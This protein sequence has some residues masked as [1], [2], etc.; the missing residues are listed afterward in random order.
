MNHLIDK[1]QLLPEVLNEFK[2]IKE[3]Q[4][5]Q[6]TIKGTIKEFKRISAS[7]F[8]VTIDRDNQYEVHAKLQI[9]LNYP[10]CPP[11][12]KITMQKR[13]FNARANQHILNRVD[14]GDLLAANNLRQLQSNA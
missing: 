5:L 14:Q 9:P 1:Q 8:E 4:M 10:D 13:S 7:L 6:N 11:T 12:F 3:F 2:S